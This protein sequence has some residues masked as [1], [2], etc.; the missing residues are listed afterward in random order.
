MSF[1]YTPCIPMQIKPIKACQ[2]KGRGTLPWRDWPC[3]PFSSTG[4]SSL[5]EFVLSQPQ[6]CGYCLPVILSSPMNSPV[7]LQVSPTA[8][9]TPTDVFSQRFEDLFLCAGTLGCVVCLAPSCSSRFI[10]T[11]CG[12]ARSASRHLT[13]VN[14]LLPCLPA[15][16]LPSPVLQPLS[17]CESSLPGC[18]SPPLLLV[19]MNVSS[20]TPW[21]SDF[22]TV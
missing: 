17:C 12:T 7:R 22:H 11:Q 18:L 5:C 14:Q 19:W 21:L 1:P 8:A 13:P 6:R 10:H 9:S 16:V 20:L 3:C 4:L 15:A 2:G